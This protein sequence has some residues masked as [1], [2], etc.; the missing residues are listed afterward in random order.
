MKVQLKLFATYRNYLPPAAEGSAIHVQVPP[1]T[2]VS[3]L[4]RQFG[5]PENGSRIV[6]INGLGTREDQVLQENDVV[7]AFPAMAGG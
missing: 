5:L 4:L 3:D 7:A 1:N 2:R 6:L